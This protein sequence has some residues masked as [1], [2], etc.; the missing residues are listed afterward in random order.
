MAQEG[1]CTQ[2][3]LFIMAFRTKNERKMYGDCTENVW[4]MYGECTEKVR[5]MYKEFTNNVWRMYG[6]CT[7]NVRR[8]HGE[9]TEN[10]RRMYGEC[11]DNVHKLYGRICT[12]SQ[13]EGQFAMSKQDA[14]TG[15]PLLTQ[16]SR[17]SDIQDFF[18]SHV[19]Q[20]STLFALFHCQRKHV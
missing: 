20:L 10:V 15:R 4:R 18:S 13:P 14:I 6:E 3:T 1:D 12:T 17:K 5:T 16:R 7:E 2:S 19:A 9:C 8:M 11:T